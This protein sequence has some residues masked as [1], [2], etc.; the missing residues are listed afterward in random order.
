M[1]VAGLPLCATITAGILAG[2]LSLALRAT[3]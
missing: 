3:A 2:M 1:T